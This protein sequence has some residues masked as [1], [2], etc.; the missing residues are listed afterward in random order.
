MSEQLHHRLWELKVPLSEPDCYGRTYHI[1]KWTLNGR[2]V[3]KRG[4]RRARGGAQSRVRMLQ[5]M[6]MRNVSPAQRASASAARLEL[7][8]VEAADTRESAR[9]S[10][11][12]DW[13]ATELK[14]HDWLPNEQA[15]RFRGQGYGFL[16]EHVYSRAATEAGIRP[17][18][19]KAWMKCVKPALL[20]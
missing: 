14:L 2:E 8:L 1:P 16:H 13:W 19:Y 5:A 18:S 7:A 4:W 20:R 11:T 10:V 3:C 15:I 6:V 17:L 12:T 9:H